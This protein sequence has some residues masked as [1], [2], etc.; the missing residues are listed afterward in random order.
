MGLGK[1]VMF[2]LP[3]VAQL[4]GGKLCG[5][6]LLVHLGALILMRYFGYLHTTHGC[7]RL[8]YRWKNFWTSQL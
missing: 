7:H 3:M 5:H 1:L 2:R 4:A 6:L 8:D